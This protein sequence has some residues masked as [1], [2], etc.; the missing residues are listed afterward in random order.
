MAATSLHK[1]TNRWLTDLGADATQG[2]EHS[3]SIG[4]PLFGREFTTYRLAAPV[5]VN[6][7]GIALF[8]LDEAEVLIDPDW[9]LPKT[10]ATRAELSAAIAEATYDG[11]LKLHGQT[12]RRGGFGN[13][14]LVKPV[15]CVSA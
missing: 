7:R 14:R 8:D 13:W 11:G 10:W 12:Y 15:A 2:S 4:H 3:L 1:P 9:R 6:E 5:T